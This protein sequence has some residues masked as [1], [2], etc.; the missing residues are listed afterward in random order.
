MLRGVCCSKCTDHVQELKQFPPQQ[1]RGTGDTITVLLLMSLTLSSDHNKVG[2]G[3][4]Q[5]CDA[6]QLVIV[7]SIILWQQLFPECCSYAST[8][9]YDVSDAS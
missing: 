5:I 9:Y 2:R 6:F 4:L 3:L 7:V 8:W 1:T